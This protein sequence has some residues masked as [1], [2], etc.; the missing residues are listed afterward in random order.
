MKHHIIFL[1][2]AIAIVGGF[3]VTN[4]LILWQID[5]PKPPEPIEGTLLLY[6][7]QMQVWYPTFGWDCANSA[8]TGELI[9]DGNDL[10]FIA[11]DDNELQIITGDANMNEAA[12][13][14]FNEYLKEMCDAYIQQKLKEPEPLTDK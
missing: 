3:S 12:E 14:F 10:E 13:V 8:E 5:E 2:I 7:G 9:L 4:Y 6:R 1:W 11:I